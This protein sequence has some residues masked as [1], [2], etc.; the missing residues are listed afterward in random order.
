[1]CTARANRTNI[2]LLTKLQSHCTRTRLT[3]THCTPLFN[4]LAHKK[5]AAAQSFLPQ[6]T[7][8]HTLFHFRP[9][10]PKLSDTEDAWHARLLFHSVTPIVRWWS[11]NTQGPPGGALYTQRTLMAHGT[12]THTHLPTYTSHTPKRHTVPL[13]QPPRRRREVAH[14]VSK[15]GSR[16][17]ERRVG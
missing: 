15:I 6:H 14:P 3:H 2:H 12:H 11:P 9:M 5:R 8:A 16:C 1:M 7:L 17:R 10:W 13:P 4:E